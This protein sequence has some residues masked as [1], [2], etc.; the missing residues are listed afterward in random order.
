M[1]AL[2]ISMNC[3]NVLLMHCLTIG[4]NSCQQPLSEIQLRVSY[5]IHLWRHK[6]RRHF[7][8]RRKGSITADSFWYSVRHK[9][10]QT[11]THIYTCTHTLTHASI[12]VWQAQYAGILGFLRVVV[13]KSNCLINRL[14]RLY[15][16]KRT[17][18]QGVDFDRSETSKSQFPNCMSH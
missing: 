9:S 17:Y 6:T 16:P 2:H 8:D 14:M 3:T 18:K 11:L 10:K 1:N 5:L 15:W 13:S 4:C 12:Y 7:V